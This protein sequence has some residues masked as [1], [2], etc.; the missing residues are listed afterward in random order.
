MHALMSTMVVC[1]LNNMNLIAHPLTKRLCPP[2]ARAM[3]IDPLIE[4]SSEYYP[5]LQV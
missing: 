4:C 2:F 3:L 5:M 1:S